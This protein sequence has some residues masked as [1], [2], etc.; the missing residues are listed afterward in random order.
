MNS[1]ARMA[2]VLVLILAVSTACVKQS[3][4]PTIPGSTTPSEQMGDVQFQAGN[5]E[6]A[7]EFYDKALDEGAAPDSVLY[8]KGFAHFA[9]DEWEKAL[10]NFQASIQANP[11]LAIAHEGAGLAAFQLEQIDAAAGHFEDTRKLAP[12]HWVPYAFLAAITQIKGQSQEAKALGD[13][14]VELGG[15][16]QRPLVIATMRDAYNRGTQMRP[17][18]KTGQKDEIIM[19]HS[20]E[21]S[22]TAPQFGSD[23]GVLASALPEPAAG[24]AV[25]EQQPRETQPTEHA[26]AEH[27][28][29]QPES[30]PPA[31]PEAKPGP[32]PMSEP[33]PAPAAK[34]AP[35]PASQPAAAP[36]GGYAILES[37]WKSEDQAKNRMAMLKNQGLPVYT[38]HVNLGSRGI[39]HRVLFGP[40]KSLGDAR[41]AKDR[42]AAQH[43]LNDL[44]ILQNR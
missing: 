11:N 12:N 4:A 29:A 9:R 31:Q 42:I 24:P 7:L 10:E 3:K 16:A 25:P 44:L 34:P 1:S 38:A 27:A 26:Q 39:W 30:V 40:F 20:G 14:A 19:E 2:L 43:N 22:D 35:E 21:E 36:V 41:S 15:E 17:G 37:S 18:V 6:R 32:A 33:K 28:A 23:S 5:F 13:K 8:R